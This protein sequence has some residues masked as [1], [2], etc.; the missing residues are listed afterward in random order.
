[1]ESA[2]VHSSGKEWTGHL[3]Y[4]CLPR[5]LLLKVL[6]LKRFCSKC[7]C[8]KCFRSKRFRSKRFRSKRFRSK[9]F[10]SKRFCSKSFCS[11][12]FRLKRFGSK[13]FCSKHFC[14]KLFRSKRFRPLKLSH[15]QVYLLACP[16]SDPLHR[17]LS[18][19]EKKIFPRKRNRRI[20]WCFPSE[21]RLFHGRPYSHAHCTI[22][23]YRRCTSLIV[24]HSLTTLLTHSQPN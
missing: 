9:R 24:T 14:S 10:R 15:S 18:F 1:M 8:S 6:L 11:K 20:F 7:F 17:G 12:R 5:E 23:T 4:G 3:F 19:N 16:A 2:T 21:L 22:C 13:N